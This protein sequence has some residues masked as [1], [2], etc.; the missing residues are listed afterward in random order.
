MYFIFYFGP[1][2]SIVR[3][4]PPPPFHPPRLR[5]DQPLPTPL[6]RVGVGESAGAEYNRRNVIYIVCNR[7]VPPSLP[8]VGSPYGGHPVRPPAHTQP[9]P[10]AKPPPTPPLLGARSF[11]LC[12]IYNSRPMV[13]GSGEGGTG[14]GPAS[15]SIP[16]S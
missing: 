15:D 9:Q 7:A 3:A 16:F 11:I 2:P 4:V 8:T 6:R 10:L 13:K 5:T 1:C 12:A 14:R